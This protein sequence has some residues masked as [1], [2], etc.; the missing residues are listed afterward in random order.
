[1]DFNHS[2]QVFNEECHIWDG[3]HIDPDGLKI[4]GFSEEQIKDPKKQ[5]EEAIIKKFLAWMEG[6]EERTVAGQNPSFDLGFIRAAANRYHLN[7]PLAHRSIDLHTIVYFHMVRR[8]TTP[9]VAHHHSALNSDFIMEYVGIPT[10]PKPHLALNGATWEAE[11][12]SRLMYEKPLL[13]QFEKYTIPWI[14]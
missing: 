6:R 5:S 13:S 1:M 3:A 8:G 11:A 14:S 10:E 12:L 9:P 2:E 7:M 4:N